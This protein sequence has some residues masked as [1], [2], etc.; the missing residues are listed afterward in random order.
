MRRLLPFLFALTTILHVL[1]ARADDDDDDDDDDEE[2][3]IIR[4]PP[5]GTGDKTPG[6]DKPS[7]GDKPA[8][9]PVAADKGRISG[10]VVDAKT[11][12]PV[13][14]AQVTVVGSTLKTLSDVEGRYTL[15]LAPG[16][17][18]LRVW[19]ELYQARRIT[20]IEVAAGQTVTIDV[21]LG[22]DQSA[23]QEV[24]VVAQ[25]DT[26][27][28]AVQLVRRKK[29]ST[30][31]DAVSAE[32]I[33]RS[34]DSNASDAVKRVVA[35]TVSEGK[36]VTIRGLGGRYSTTLLNGVQMPSVDPDQPSV[37]LDLFPAALL[38][39]LT[40]VKTFSPDI[41]GNFAGGS[42]NIETRDFPTKFGL[43]LKLGVGAN[44]ETTFRNTRTYEGGGLD[45]LGFDDGTRKLPSLVPTKAP[46]LDSNFTAANIERV[47][48][49]FQ[50][51]WSTR[52]KTAMPNASLGATIGDTVR[53]GR[54]K[55]G[56]LATASYGHKVERRRPTIRKLADAGPIE[57]FTSEVGIESTSIGALGSVGLELDKSN[58]LGMIWLYSHSHDD[59]AQFVSGFSNED[60][61]NIEGTRLQWVERQLLFGQLTG[62]HALMKNRLN[63]S[64]QGNLSLGSRSE[65]D[66][67]DT[68][69]NQELANFQFENGP[70]SG[71]RFFSRLSDLNG[72]GGL[73]VTVPFKPLRVKLGGAVQASTRGFD[74]RRFRFRVFDDSLLALRPAEQLFTPGNIAPN[75]IEVSE[76]TLAADS[77][78]AT[79]KVFAGYAMFDVTALEPFRLIAG[80]RY[81]HSQQTLQD[82]SKFA[83][84][85]TRDDVD[86]KY[87]DVLPGANLVYALSDTINL[88]GAYSMTV[89]RPQFREMAPFSFFDYSKRRSVSGNTALTETRIHNADLRFEK[90]LAATELLAGSLFYKRF[91]DPIESVI[92][93]A[94]GDIQFKNA[95]GADT[96]GLELEGRINLRHLHKQLREVDLGANLSLIRSRVDLSAEQAAQSTNTERPL[97]GQSP[98]VVN[99][100]LGWAHACTGSQLSILYNV[101]G[102][103]ITDVGA[104][105]LDDVKEQPF[106][107]VD[108]SYNQKL[109]GR[110]GLKLAATNVLNQDVVRRQGAFDIERYASGIGLSASLEWSPY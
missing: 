46:L 48:E 26:A 23:V 76:T 96:Y 51:V 74:A 57:E 7:G 47:G 53:L 81:E 41:P 36:Y 1:P 105:P 87:D 55:L 63:L 24:V 32:Q 107:R 37:P 20:Q 94:T 19:Y 75:R 100:E 109:P 80:V 65:P 35:A 16:T 84:D 29:A 89:A 40:V 73:H 50:N 99:V 28:A 97:Q 62:E 110:L 30:V 9:A 67:R 103:R 56:Y 106:H 21:Q 83:V 13:I 25:P 78:D 70:G 45:L 86:R 66:T 88:R 8:D 77:Y 108:V 98:Y 18:T 101:F 39:N 61:K 11:G 12:E 5:P 95:D 15:T 91:S 82:G 54:R 2:P 93:S 6:G 27:T 102:P 3:I 4:K 52:R 17:Y 69:Y 43:K 10:L 79:L 38:A 68:N 64:W 71:E 85:Q 49:S 60:N 58:R 22:S 31:S 90:Y 104:V 33:A 59:R 14:E 92:T 34:P 42:L 44:S 72:G